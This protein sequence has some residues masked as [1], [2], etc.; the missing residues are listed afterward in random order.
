MLSVDSVEGRH[1][2]RYACVASNFAG[3]VE[4]ASVLIVNGLWK[5]YCVRFVISSPNF[6]DGSAV[7]FQ[8]LLDALHLF[9]VNVYI[10]NLT[11]LL[12]CWK[13]S[14]KNRTVHLR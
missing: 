1:A 4:W 11:L 6:P 14:T 9:L 12:C 13:S 5:L 8:P 3:T 10:F 2:G 7:F